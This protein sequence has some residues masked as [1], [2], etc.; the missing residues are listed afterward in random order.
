MEK[1]NSEIH[2][3]TE[4]NL[5]KLFVFKNLFINQLKCNFLYNF[6]SPLGPKRLL[7]ESPR[8]CLGV[9]EN[10]VLGTYHWIIWREACVI[11]CQ[12][13][14]K[15]M[16]LEKLPFY[17]LSLPTPPQFYM[18]SMNDCRLFPFPFLKTAFKIIKKKPFSF[19]L[20]YNFISFIYS[21]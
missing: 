1:N 6:E 4:P 19:V 9:Q 7:F 10:P 15:N 5:H 14:K 3:Q 11:F 17:L 20:Y 18:F 13:E 16:F 8:Q 21:L 2:I 12:K